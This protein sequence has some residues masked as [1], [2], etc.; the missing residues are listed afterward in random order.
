MG[1]M[2]DRFLFAWTSEAKKLVNALMEKSK[3][4]IDLLEWDKLG[5]LEENEERVQQIKDWYTME[6]FGEI[7]H[8]SSVILECPER[9]TIN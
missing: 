5:V 6:T 2:Q 4:I 8:G 1:T 3:L 7:K 9:V